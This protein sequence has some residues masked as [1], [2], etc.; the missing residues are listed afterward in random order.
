[1]SK[2]FLVLFLKKEL[3]AFTLRESGSMPI[4]IT[5]GEC[6]KIFNFGQR[7]TR[8]CPV[9]GGAEVV[10]NDCLGRKSVVEHPFASAF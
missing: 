4:D 10:S 7:S 9:S 1:M 8:L 2:S 6:P 3:L 5:T